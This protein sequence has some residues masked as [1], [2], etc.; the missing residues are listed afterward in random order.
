VEIEGLNDVDWTAPWL[1]PFADLGREIAAAEDWRSALNHRARRQGIT[2]ANG[3]PLVFDRPEAAQSEAYESFIARSGRVPTRA[4]TH[5]FFNALVW[6][7]FPRSKA[8][9]NSLQAAAIERSGVGSTRGPLRDAA[10]LVDENAVLL[11]TRRADL[12][13][14]L[15][16]RDWTQLFRAERAAWNGEIRVLAFGHA[17]LQKLVHPYKAITAHALHVGLA[18]TAD[19]EA[20]DAAVAAQL[21]QQLSPRMLLPLPVLGIPGWW[22]ANAEPAFYADPAVFRP[23]R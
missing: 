10:T 4:N 11:V 22:T 20:A 5:D 15:G 8:R 6:L 12:V 23:P 7:R 3:L 18:A 17:L 9:L 13:D 16:S 14:A 1:E 21:D 2:T 19:A